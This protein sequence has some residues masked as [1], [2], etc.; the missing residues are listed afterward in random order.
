MFCSDEDVDVL[1]LFVLF[2]FFLDTFLSTVS[3]SIV[4]RF[5]VETIRVK[6]GRSEISVIPDILLDIVLNDCVL[7]SPL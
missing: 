3:L 1:F 5:S 7:Q 2:C 4:F 6:F